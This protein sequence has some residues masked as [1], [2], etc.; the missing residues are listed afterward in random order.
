MLNKEDITNICKSAL[1]E[2]QFIV[3]V[4]ISASNDIFV[5]VD[6]FNGL[7]IEECQRISKEIES[8]LDRE[9]ADFSLELG[10]PGLSNPFKVFEQYQKHLGKEVE[11]LM[12]DG[13]KHTGTLSTASPDEIMLSYTYVAKMANKK[14]E[15]SEIIKIRVQDIKSTRSVI[16]FK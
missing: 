6:D 14:Q 10:S 16:S 13:E 1:T 3:E 15:I 2:N 7:S 12:I 9:V 8:Q 5:S 4:K 11:V